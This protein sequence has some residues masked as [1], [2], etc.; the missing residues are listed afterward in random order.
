MQHAKTDQ[1]G[2][3]CVKIASLQIGSGSG[4]RRHQKRYLLGHCLVPWMSF[5]VMR[6]LR[7]LELETREC[8]SIFHHLCKL[9][10]LTSFLIVSFWPFQGYIYWD[11]C[12]CSRC[13]G[14]NF[15]WWESRVSPGRSSAE[16]WF[17]CPRRCKG[18]EV[19]WSERSL[20][21]PL[22]CGQLSAGMNY[23]QQQSFLWI[24]PTFVCSPLS[25]PSLF[26]TVRWQME[27]ETWTSGTVT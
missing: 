8:G 26:N 27:G 15:T 10:W 14:I 2:P 7:R 17:R 21:S 3:F 16:E 5:C 1:D 4:C 25:F 12:C 11:G 24:K 22:F 18:L 19:T 9:I 13:Y 20:L 6:L 23:F